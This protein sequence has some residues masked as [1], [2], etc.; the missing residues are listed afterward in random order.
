MP[1]SLLLLLRPRH[2]Q[3]LAHLVQ[4]MRDALLSLVSHLRWRGETKKSGRAKEAG[5]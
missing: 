3:L 5:V 2:V 4:A 1:W